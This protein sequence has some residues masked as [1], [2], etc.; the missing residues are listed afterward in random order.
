MVPRLALVVG[1]VEPAVASED[2]VARVVGVDPDR[3][4]VGVHARARVCAHSLAPVFGHAEP[5]AADVDPVRVVRVGLDSAEVHGSGVVAVH[6][7]PAV[8]AILRAVQPAPLE[9]VRPL[10]VLD[11]GALAA[12][13]RA[14]G[15]ALARAVAFAQGD[16]NLHG[17]T[18]AR[19][20]EW[21]RVAGHALIDLVDQILVRQDRPVA[22]G[23]DDVAGEQS[24]IFRGAFFGDFSEF[25]AGVGVLTHDAHVGH[26]LRDRPDPLGIDLE[27]DDVRVAE[28][29]GDAHPSEIDGGQA[30]G[31]LGESGPGI[32]GLVQGGARPPFLRGVVGI[33]PVAH[34]FPRRDQ[35]RVGIARVHRDIDHAGG[36]VDVEDFVPVL[37]A[38]GG[39]EEPA[40]LVVAPAAAHGADVDDVGILGVNDDLTDLERLLES[41]VLPCVAAVGALVDAVAPGDTV[42]RVG[43]ARADPDDVRVRGRDSDGTDGNGCLIVELVLVR[44]AVVRRLEQPAGRGGDVVDGRV[45][46]INGDVGDA[47]AHVGRADRAPLERVGPGRLEAQCC[48][49]LR[50]DR[51]RKT[52]RERAGCKQTDSHKRH[53]R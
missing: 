34:S 32:G 49:R 36:L 16:L 52:Q 28:V 51:C 1:D 9:G 10:L 45:G 7:G 26:L 50:R 6:A 18:L 24:A 39:L 31:D 42:A 2:D 8:A 47:T 46:F 29:V 19:D 48:R 14:E 22:D 11:V 3:V 15:S 25:G 33:E 12:E 4:L 20:S 44:H 35:Q 27:V 21:H 41:H 53:G 43:L 17:L 30:V 37:P 5:D 40:L 38:V 23:D 13:A